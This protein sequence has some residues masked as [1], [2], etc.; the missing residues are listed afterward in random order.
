MTMF[1]LGSGTTH[2]CKAFNAIKKMV[3]DHI[4]LAAFDE[5][6]PNKAR[7]YTGYVW[8]WIWFS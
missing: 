7:A 3:K 4:S 8:E 5:A 6:S 1:F 2:G